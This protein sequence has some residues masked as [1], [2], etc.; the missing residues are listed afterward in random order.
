MRFTAWVYLMTNWSRSVLYV[1][2]TTDLPKR[3]WEHR[4]K[5]D[6][7]SFTAR[8]ST[9]RLVFYQGF[10]SATEAEDAVRFIKGQTRAWK[11][12]LIS[13][14]NPKWKDLTA[15]VRATFGS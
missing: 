8:Y 14:R 2:F 12:A 13:H 9:N 10:L 7:G 3:L 11:H 1:D 4:T 5:Q 15:E 6:P